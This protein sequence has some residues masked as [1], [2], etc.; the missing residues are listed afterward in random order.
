MNYVEA[1]QLRTVVYIRRG[2]D[3]VARSAGRAIKNAKFKAGLFRFDARQ[4]RRLAA[5]R[6]G[7]AQRV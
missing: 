6:T 7:W 2:N 3:T 1:V 5:S 4:Y